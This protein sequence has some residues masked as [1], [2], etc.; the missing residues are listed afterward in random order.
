MVQE[1]QENNA[2]GLDDMPHLTLSQDELTPALSSLDHS[3]LEPSEHTSDLSQAAALNLES[4]S[5]EH[6][7]SDF[8]ASLSSSATK[9]TISTKSAT[10]DISNAS[11][12]SSESAN[13]GESASTT[14]MVTPAASMTSTAA[15]TTTA[16][17]A[18]SLSI[19]K[20]SS[21]AS[22]GS[23]ALQSK[24]T[25]TSQP[26][27]ISNS[28]GS[29]QAFDLPSYSV[30]FLS[31]NSQVAKQPA[32]KAV[33]AETKSQ[34]KSLAKSEDKAVV[35]HASYSSISTQSASNQSTQDKVKSEVK[36]RL[37]SG[38]KSESAAQAAVS[39][40]SQA[41]SLSR[42]PQAA[43]SGTSS[44]DAESKTEEVKAPE[45]Q[46]V[47]SAP[48]AKD[49]NVSSA[50]VANKTRSAQAQATYQNT[51]RLQKERSLAHLKVQR[52]ASTT[53]TSAAYA[54]ASS[55][56]ST[57][58]ATNQDKSKVA[59]H[60]S[61]SA[62]PYAGSGT[63]VASNLAANSS[64]DEQ[65]AKTLAD[66]AKAKLVPNGYGHKASDRNAI[67]PSAVA[68]IPVSHLN[69]LSEK[70]SEQFGSKRWLRFLCGMTALMAGI[71][72]FAEHQWHIFGWEKESYIDP[73]QTIASTSPYLVDSAVIMPGS[74]ASDAR[75]A[76]SVNNGLHQQ[77]TET[78]DP[79][80][81]KLGEHNFTV[82]PLYSAAEINERISVQGCNLDRIFME[83]QPGRRIRPKDQACK[84]IHQM[85][86]NYYAL[87]VQLRSY[88][89]DRKK[90]HEL[91]QA[92]NATPE[93]IMA[94][95]FPGKSKASVQG[96][97]L[98][99]E[100][101]LGN[102]DKRQ[103]FVFP[104]ASA[105]TMANRW[106]EW[107]NGKCLGQKFLNLDTFKTY[108]FETALLDLSLLPHDSSLFPYADGNERSEIRLV[109]SQLNS[110]GRNVGR[111]DGIVGAKT[112]QEIR[113]IENELFKNVFVSD[114][115]TGMNG[116]ISHALLLMLYFLDSG[117]D[118]QSSRYL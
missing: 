25:N 96:W 90:R 3:S 68:Q 27:A 14:H 4:S 19:S 71:L 21:K 95:T 81:A 110:L 46:A 97:C 34:P 1:S 77:T 91:K 35:P 117:F 89:S 40:P 10:L 58:K 72:L 59:R 16:V 115:Y 73:Q 28:P 64:Q 51:A 85:L 12:S 20:S 69:E 93:R 47:L 57:H 80:N 114:S 54:S 82:I 101:T 79:G 105:R 70:A 92:I 62:L 53:A 107:Y 2:L 76:G 6:P 88:L 61:S 98:V 102:L 118:N 67:E 11:H 99:I 42:K 49:S 38:A 111:P 18:S 24:A 86:S 52:T 33:Q 50:S 55:S 108:P 36:V 78:A 30:L 63:Q 41:S 65:D 74:D 8:S 112:K 26:A 75:A 60:N 100:D 116:D 37:E 103:R 5:L 109:Q 106:I 29:S 104:T 83:P 13:P 22:S 44:K 45:K 9:F 39:Q 31:S 113:K 32:D 66:Q 7:Q 94:Y 17:S 56:A 48:A 84:S 23:N 43:T 87:S 15:T